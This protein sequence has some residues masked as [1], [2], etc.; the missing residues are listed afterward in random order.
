VDPPR[1]LRG[2]QAHPARQP[3]DGGLGG[4]EVDAHL[5][6][7]EVIGVEIAEQEVGVRDR[8][9]RSPE[10]IGGRTG[11]GARAPRAHLEQPDLVDLGDAAAARADLD[12]LDGGDADG[13]ARALDEAPLA[14]GLEAVRGQ[15][16]AAVHEGE[17]RRR[18]AHVEGEEIA[19]A[20]RRAEEGGGD[21]AGGRA[22]LEHRDGGALGLGDVGEP[23]AREHEQERRGDAEPC[24]LSGHHREVL[25]G[26]RLDVGVD[27]GG[28]RALV[29]A[30][31]RRHLVGGRRRDFGMALGD[32]PDRLDLVAGIGVGVQED[33]G[34][35][36]DT[37]PPEP[38]EPDGELNRVERLPHAAVGLRPLVD[39]EAEV[40]RDEGLG[41]GDVQII[42]LELALPPDLEGVR[43]P[44]RRD[45]SR[46]GARALD[47]GIG[48]E[49]GRVHDPRHARRIDACCL[50]QG[51]DAGPDGTGGI[52]V[53]GEDLLA[54]LA[55]GVVVVDHDVGERAADV[56]AER[57]VG[58]RASSDGQN[59]RVKAGPGSS[60]KRVY[61]LWA[62]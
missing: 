62:A 29:L 26:E 25:L 2:G 46:A 38:A 7:R 20:V 53:G 9:I 41:L 45:Q 5:A 40:A 59:G 49:R 43:E 21:G 57:V 47:E 19:A 34:D 33:D 10:A 48:E 12:Q 61:P 44:G 54:P 56:D 18:A 60:A 13:Q 31:L 3:L 11:L 1:D 30:D 28:G 4:R 8:G 23:A 50:E 32:E 22:R 17:L 36:R 51:D 52:V 15:G 27:G 58:Q 24:Q 35:R 6:P 14:R 39:L 37:A 16:L 42:E 55:S